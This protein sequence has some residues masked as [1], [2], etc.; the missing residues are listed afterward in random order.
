VP[1][2]IQ[3]ISRRSQNSR[4]TASG[5]SLRGA[6]VRIEYGVRIVR[7]PAGSLLAVE[8]EFWLRRDID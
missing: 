6:Q 7:D 1:P 4:S 5:R 2:G 8:R 3:S